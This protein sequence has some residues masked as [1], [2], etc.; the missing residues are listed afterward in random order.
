MDTLTKTVYDAVMGYARKGLNSQSY[1]THD[2]D[3]TIFSV[4]TVTT[5]NTSFVSL[6]VRISN[7][8]VIVEQDRNNKTLVDALLQA[9]IPRESIIL[10]YKGEPTP[11]AA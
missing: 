4:V 5:N 2:D 7:S 6:L 3:N 11:A 1:F 8:M 9:G 10:A